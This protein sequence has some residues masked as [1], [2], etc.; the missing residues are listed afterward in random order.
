MLR[1]AICCGGGFSSSALAAI[2]E[3][4]VKKLNKEE[5]ISFVFMPFHEVF[6]R[7]DEVDIAMC[8]PHL[9]WKVKDVAKDYSIPITIIPP[10]LYGLMTARDFIED[11]EDLKAL[12]DQK[13]TNPI[14]FDDE[15]NILKVQRNISHRRYLNHEVAKFDS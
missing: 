15:Q 14:Y 6:K 4:G 5:E 10:R 8:C 7:Q 1:V 9:Q 12:W 11:A 13:H 2:L 3:G